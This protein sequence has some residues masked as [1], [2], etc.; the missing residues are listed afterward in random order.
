MDRNNSAAPAA[1][2]AGSAEWT[3]SPDKLGAPS[4]WS[5]GSDYNEGLTPDAVDT[6]SRLGVETHVI[7]CAD[8]V[9]SFDAP[10]TYWRS[11]IRSLTDTACS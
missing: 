8:H 3:P 2:L 9:A 7:P 10:R 5:V 1:A 6:A 4:L 11:W